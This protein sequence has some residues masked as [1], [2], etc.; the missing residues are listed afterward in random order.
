MLRNSNRQIRQRLRPWSERLYENEGFR[1][2]L[3]DDQASRLLNW[4]LE[5]LS[6]A[7][8]ETL[9]LNDLEA[10]EHLEEVWLP[11]SRVIRQINTLTTLLPTV[12]DD[13]E[14]GILVDAFAGS[15]SELTGKEVKY[16][17]IDG[18]VEQR[19]ELDAAA[20]FDHLLTLLLPPTPP[21]EPTPDPPPAIKSE[22]LHHPD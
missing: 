6:A 5:I 20:T 2:G 1:D 9:P 7:A 17:W 10:E 18:L 3:D 21:S 15:V 16:D 22:Q 12:V 11:L 14:A 8:A 19:G 4:G 13:G